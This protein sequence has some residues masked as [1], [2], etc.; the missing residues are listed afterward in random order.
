MNIFLK[1]TC[2]LVL[3]TSLFSCQKEEEPT[4]PEVIIPYA[5]QYPVDLALMDSFLSEYSLQFDANMNV[6]FTKL[7][8]TGLVAIKDDPSLTVNHV[9]EKVAGID[10]KLY[11]IKLRQGV[12][13]K[14]SAID[15]VYV[16][17]K[18]YYL[19]TPLTTTAEKLVL[20][21]QI[22]NPIWFM[23]KDYADPRNDVVRGWQEIMRLFNSG[24][25]TSNPTNG[26][27]SYSDF[28]SGVMVIPSAFGYYNAQRGSLPKY[29]PLVFSFNL[30]RVNLIDHDR[31]RVNSIDEDT[32]G[33]GF[34]TNDDADGDGIQNLFDTDD[35]G[36]GIPT[37]VEIRKPI[38]ELGL[39]AY[40]PFN[41]TL[42]DPN[43]L[44]NESEINGIPSCSGDKTTL[45]RLHKH[46]DKNCN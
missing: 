33:D 34:F 18:T 4:P 15:S 26:Q 3:A 25:Y 6:T 14:P 10:H 37:K 31:D 19:N 38:G 7:P 43:T 8:M 24:N 45:T 9:I 44:Y 39:S 29:S 13:Q 1:F 27:I 30:M 17:Y 12:G 36:D 16:N 35:D 23:L 11:Y 2:L 40:Y 41:P 5:F 32:N 20:V 22:E 42:D 46:L 28:G 21:D